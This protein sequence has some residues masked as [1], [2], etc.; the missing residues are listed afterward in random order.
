MV[1]ADVVILGGRL[2][3]VADAFALSRRTLR[4][5]RHNF[6]ISAIYNVVA[7]PLAVFG[8]VTP[9]V[10]AVLM[11]LSSLAVLVSAL[12]LRR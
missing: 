5:I 1:A 8:L 12:R 4:V 6:T 3:A 2:G 11:P 10:A 9:L 7:I